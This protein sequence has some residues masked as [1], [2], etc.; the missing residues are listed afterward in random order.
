[1]IKTFEKYLV[2]L[3]LKKLLI[4]SAIFMSLIIIISVFDEISYF[5]NSQLGFFFPVV[6]TILNA[7]SVLF[8]IFPFIFLISSQFFFFRFD[9]YR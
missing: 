7:P 4:V 1:M 3:Y 5:K 2:K 9:Q 8:Q 6:I